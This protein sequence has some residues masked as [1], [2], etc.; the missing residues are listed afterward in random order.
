MEQK[1]FTTDEIVL[2]A[3]KEKQGFETNKGDIGY[4]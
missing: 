2:I 1:I 4:D 3:I